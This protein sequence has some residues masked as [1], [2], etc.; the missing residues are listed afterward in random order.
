MGESDDDKPCIARLPSGELL[1]TAFHQHK[2]NGNKADEPGVTVLDGGGQTV[3]V[4]EPVTGD[5]TGAVLLWKSG[6]LASVKGKTASLR[7]I[8]RNARVYSFWCK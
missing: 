3:A 6:D 7:L 8:I 4:A 5:Q 1:L 2:R